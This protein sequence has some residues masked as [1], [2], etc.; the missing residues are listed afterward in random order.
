MSLDHRPVTSSGKAASG[1]DPRIRHRIQIGMFRPI[2]VD[3]TNCLQVAIKTHSFIIT[4]VST[5]YDSIKLGPPIVRH[6][7]S[8]VPL[9]SMNPSWLHLILALVPCRKQRR[10]STASLRNASL[11]E[12]RVSRIERLGSTLRFDRFVSVVSDSTL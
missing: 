10:A 11:R 7:A 5:Q 3:H 2:R 9:Y 4:L 6:K 12:T 1:P 8:E